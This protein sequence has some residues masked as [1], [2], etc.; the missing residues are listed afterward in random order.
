[1]KFQKNVITGSIAE[2]WEASRTLVVSDG[3]GQEIPQRLKGTLKERPCLLHLR[4]PG[5]LGCCCVL[6]PPGEALGRLRGDL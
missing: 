3:A 1:M 5:A 2:Q 6:P 4:G